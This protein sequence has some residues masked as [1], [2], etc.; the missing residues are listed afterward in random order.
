MPS[1]PLVS[2]VIPSY[3]GARFLPETLRGVLQ[4]THPKVEVIV[5]DDGSTDDTP[6]V[7]AA[8]G[9]DV[10]YVRQEN[11]GVSAARNRGIGLAKGEYIAFLDADDVWLPRKLECQ[12]SCIADSTRIGIV[13]CAY[14]ITDEKLQIQCT[15][16]PQ[17][18]TLC[19]LLLLRGNGGLFGSTILAPKAV[20]NELGGFD[21]R[22]STSADWDLATR[23]ANRY[24]VAVT[25]EPL[26]Y[27]RQHGGNMH[28]GIRRTEEDML[29]VLRKAFQEHLPSSVAQLRRRAYGNLYRML[30]GS[31]WHGANPLHAMRCGIKSFLWHP[32]I[33]THLIALPVRKLRTRGAPNCIP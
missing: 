23:I 10:T 33:L 2:V 12:L 7:V 9:G 18:C 3:N 16:S 32:A 19:D 20:L 8:F 11:S 4:Q 24:V 29:L 5:V 14:H 25:P 6:A 26:V 31:Y 28:Q 21:E 27:Y 22:L 1:P 15:I 13:G 17:S 30:A